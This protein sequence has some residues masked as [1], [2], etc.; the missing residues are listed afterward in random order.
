MKT[1]GFEGRKYSNLGTFRYTGTTVYI[2][3]FI[4]RLYHMTRRIRNYNMMSAFYRLW[5]C[6]AAVRVP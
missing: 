5:L 6:T 1:N 3:F 4:I 2:L